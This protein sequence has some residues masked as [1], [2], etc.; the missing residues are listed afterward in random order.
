MSFS[1]YAPIIK[2]QMDESVSAIRNNNGKMISRL[3]LIQKLLFK[4]FTSSI[5]KT[6]NI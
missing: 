2:K 4:N 5:F 6:K 1:L 3:G